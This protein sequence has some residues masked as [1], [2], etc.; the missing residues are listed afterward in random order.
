MSTEELTLVRGTQLPIIP[1]PRAAPQAVN[2]A[3]WLRTHKYIL[4]RR[5]RQSRVLLH[6]KHLLA[7]H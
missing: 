7:Q 1:S 6:R 3:G 2:L 5:T 4:F